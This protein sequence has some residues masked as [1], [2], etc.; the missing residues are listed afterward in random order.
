MYHYHFAIKTRL[1][2]LLFTP[3]PD[4]ASAFRLSRSAFSG[5]LLA[6]HNPL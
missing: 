3:A 5:N 1:F 4:R 6:G 2:E